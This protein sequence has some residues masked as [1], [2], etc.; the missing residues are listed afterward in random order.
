MASNCLIDHIHLLYRHT[1]LS[2]LS[3]SLHLT[4]FIDSTSMR[5]SLPYYEGKRGK[6]TLGIICILLYNTSFRD[7]SGKSFTSEE[8]ANILEA[9]ARRFSQA[10]FIVKLDV[11][12]RSTDI[13]I[14]A[15]GPFC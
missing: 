9:V 11:I 3:L 14:S 6:K 7:A 1:T 13:N 5:F 4:Q 15:K 2:Y 8:I 12:V 10:H